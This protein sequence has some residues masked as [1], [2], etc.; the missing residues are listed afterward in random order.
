M[1]WADESLIK[2]DVTVNA[3]LAGTIVELLA[4]EEDTVAVGQELFRIDAGEGGTLLLRNSLCLAH[5]DLLRLAAA[6]PKEKAAEEPTQAEPPKT[7]EAA[8][9]QQQP[10]PPPAP[11]QKSTPETPKEPKA[12]KQESKPEAAAP[13]R[14][15]GSRNETRVSY[16]SPLSR[17]F[18]PLTVT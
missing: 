9:P 16:Y 7:A 8:P 4:K 3:P 1:T 12:V 14:V 6:A 13:S 10:T 5:P 2:I 18:C 17:Q 11:S 15:P